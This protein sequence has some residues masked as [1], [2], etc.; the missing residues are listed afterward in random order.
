[1]RGTNQEVRLPS[2][3]QGKPESQQAAR[4][5]H[6]KRWGAIWDIRRERETQP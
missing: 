1:M 6:G 2:L 3:T 5:Q 4:R